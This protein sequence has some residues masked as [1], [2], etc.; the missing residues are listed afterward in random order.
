MLCSNVHIGIHFCIFYENTGA[1]TGIQVGI[2][3]KTV[4]VAAA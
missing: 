1:F 4:V 2:K 3:F